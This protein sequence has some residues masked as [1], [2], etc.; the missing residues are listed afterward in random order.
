MKSKKAFIICAVCF[1]VWTTYGQINEGKTFIDWN[2]VEMPVSPNAASLGT[3]GEIQVS[4]AT[5]IPNITI[6]IYTLQV[7]GVS[8]PISLSYHASGIQV[9]ELATAVGL[10]WTLNAGGGIFR[11]VSGKPDED[12]WLSPGN[13]PLTNED[14]Y[15]D[16]IVGDPFMQSMMNGTE[17]GPGLA[18]TRD[19]NP[20][21]YNYSFLGFSGNYITDFGG[22]VIKNQADN[23]TIDGTTI[24]DQMGNTYNFGQTGYVETSNRTFSYNSVRTGGGLIN[25]NGYSYDSDIETGWM[26]TTIQT[27]NNKTISF[28]YEPYFI[29]EHTPHNISNT[30]ASGSSCA[31][32]PFDYYAEK[33][34]T[35]V[36]NDYSVQLVKKISSENV[37]ILFDYSFPDQNLSTWKK[38][39]NMITINDK[40]TGTSKEFHFE[41]ERY[42]GD[43]RLRLKRVYEKKGAQELPGYSF[44]YVEGHLPNKYDFSQDF[45]GYYN[46]KVNFS[47]APRDQVLKD[48]YFDVN[49][50]TFYE[51]NTGDRSH[52]YNYLKIGVLESLTYP[53]G[54]STK[55]TYQANA[56]FDTVFQKVKYCGGLRVSKIED[57]DKTGTVLKT[58]S[59]TYEGLEGDSYQTNLEN[60]IT[61][62]DGG[63]EKYIIHSS[64]VAK[65]DL[66]LNGY[67][68][69]KVTSVV[70][71]DGKQQK[72]E[73]NF[74]EN[75][76]FG[77][78]G[79]LLLSEKI[80][81]VNNI[82]KLVEYDYERIGIDKS[83]N[84]NVLGDRQCLLYQITYFMGYGFGKNIVY[85]GNWTMLPTL[86]ATTN[87]LKQGSTNDAVTT[88]QEFDYD[89][90]TLLKLTEINDTR[91]TR[92][93]DQYGT[94]TYPVRDSNGERITIDY[95]YPLT[96]VNAN[97][98]GT[99]PQGLLIRKEVSSDRHDGKI[100]GQAYEYDTVGNI[101]KTFE[102]NKGVIGN[103]S[104][105]GYVDDYEEISSFIYENGKPVQMLRKNG[106]ATSYIWGYNGQYPVAKIEGKALAGLNT[107]LV[108][109]IKAENNESALRG[110][111]NQL[112]NDATTANALVTTYTY[113]P[114]NGVKTITDPKGDKNTFFY[115]SFGRLIQV[116]DKN[117]KILTENEYNYAH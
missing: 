114:L 50:Q 79:N 104:T 51:A 55:F 39:L 29:Q 95:K 98:P 37:D 76:S 12:G 49:F 11:S 67:F 48:A 74:I 80:F 3:Y 112:R 91:K 102:Y 84:W 35:S 13:G 26:L 60:L 30:I 85:D 75:L 18:E 6:P 89:D 8:V 34:S 9:N 99:I 92:E 90:E 21:N 14:W 53:T 43:H 65:Q 83:V 41:Y 20:D 42:E 115:D 27:K 100:F 25:N 23:L 44:G 64:F 117:D 17:N 66:I 54:G 81:N 68:Y 93:E 96:P 107:T 88:I 32:G 40:V 82:A 103:N 77:T 59:Y 45:F 24:E 87:Y 56:E 38:K 58:T 19:H 73:S 72:K 33:T 101:K 71:Y 36:F 70:T 116:R 110:L 105:L 7:D 10:K 69:K 109:Q 61:H 28:T 113:E 4:P 47:L 5:G 97:L 63:H 16:F 22:E 106:V 94:V 108:S 78:R 62:E 31:I 86:I 1:M 46:G 52:D 57:R 15:D 111:L 2:N